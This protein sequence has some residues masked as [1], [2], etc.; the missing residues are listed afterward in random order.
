M[1]CQ[2]C[3]HDVDLTETTDVASRPEFRDR[4]RN[5]TLPSALHVDMDGEAREVVVEGYFSFDFT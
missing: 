1:N 2:V 4:L 3:R 5:V